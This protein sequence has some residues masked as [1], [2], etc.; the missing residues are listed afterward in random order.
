MAGRLSVHDHARRHRDVDR[1]SVGDVDA[2]AATRW[3]AASPTATTCAGD[4]GGPAV[5]RTAAGRELLVGIVSFGIEQVPCRSAVTV[6]TRVAAFRP[7]LRT[8]VKP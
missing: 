5:V 8:A 3:C 1:V 4:S 7:W 6:L 2:F